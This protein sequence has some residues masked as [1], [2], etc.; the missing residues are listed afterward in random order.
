MHNLKLPILMDTHIWIW[1]MEGNPILADTN[2]LSIIEQAAESGM[3]R[4]SAISVREIGMLEAKTRISFNIPCMEWIHEAL[5]IPGLQLVPLTPEIAI[6]S[7]RLP[8]SFHGDSADRII[9]ATARILNAS[10][11]TKDKK[12]LEYAKSGFLKT[13]GISTN[14]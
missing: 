2:A 9:A 7:T 8:D 11:I 13:I 5:S 6:E 14:T 3:L 4:V 10:L 1:L 12:I